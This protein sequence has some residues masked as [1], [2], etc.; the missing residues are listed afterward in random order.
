MNE[1]AKLVSDLFEIDLYEIY[2]IESNRSKGVAINSVLPIEI[3]KAINQTFKL[4]SQ[5][6]AKKRQGINLP[7][8]DDRERSQSHITSENA[9]V[10]YPLHESELSYLEDIE[11]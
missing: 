1:D 9:M 5:P 8:R 11:G 7:E 2:D 4:D 10:A 6:R 3:Q